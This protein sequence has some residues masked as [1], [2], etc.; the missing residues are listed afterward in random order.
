MLASQ[1]LWNCWQQSNR[2]WGSQRIRWVGD[3]EKNGRGSKSCR[4]GNSTASPIKLFFFFWQVKAPSSYISKALY[5]T[6]QESPNLSTREAGTKFHGWGGRAIARAFSS[7]AQEK[8]WK[9][10][11]NNETTFST[12]FLDSCLS[13]SSAGHINQGCGNFFFWPLVFRGKT[14]P[15]HISKKETL[16]STPREEQI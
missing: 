2:M 10:E 12:V 8:C 3:R 5:I 15:G 11:F 9:Q 16:F 7:V 6:S 14:S 1:G 4:I 13:L